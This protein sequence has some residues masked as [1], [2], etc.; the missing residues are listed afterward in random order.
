LLIAEEARQAPEIVLDLLGG[1]M[2][3]IISNCI[4][5]N[6]ADAV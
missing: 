2:W 4:L 6:W 3:I 5:T 1:Q